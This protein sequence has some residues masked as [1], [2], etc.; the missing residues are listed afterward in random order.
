MTWLSGFLVGFITGMIY[1]AY[2][3]PLLYHMVLP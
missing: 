3:H 1:I 2:V